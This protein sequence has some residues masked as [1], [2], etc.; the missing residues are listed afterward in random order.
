LSSSF[1]ELNS[2]LTETIDILDETGNK[3]GESSWEELNRG[4][5]SYGRNLSLTNEELA[6]YKSLVE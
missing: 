4:V 6:T 5:D 2:V 3:I 1:N